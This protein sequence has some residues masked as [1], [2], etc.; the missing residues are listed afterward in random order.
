MPARA[1][2]T[3]F[4]CIPLGGRRLTR[5]LASFRA[6]VTS[7]NSH[8]IPD[9]AVRP[10][11][12]LHLTLGVMSLPSQ[13]QL[14]R[15]VELL[16]GLNLREL[17]G[18]VRA[19]LARQQKGSDGAAD[20][21]ARPLIALRGLQTMQS[22]AKTSVLYAP[23][24][25]VDGS[26]T[27]VGL[28]EAVKKVFVERGVMADDGRPLLLHA[29]VVNTIYAKDERGRRRKDRLMLD[30]R[31]LVAQY[32]DYEWVDGLYVRGF[33]LCKM[34]AKSIGNGDQAYEQVAFVSF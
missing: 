30:S 28:C 15:A 29:T 19:S 14:D 12:T 27:L 18:G 25:D 4:L 10:P 7:I 31:G 2:P 32:A 34:G 22:P 6:D 17:V 24:V 23:P 1:A 16:R 33:S 11:G 21:Q 8:A 26:G 13:T 20:A 9:D 5:S 3:H